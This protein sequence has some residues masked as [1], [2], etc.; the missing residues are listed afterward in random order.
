MLLIICC[1][2][3]CTVECVEL[4]LVKNLSEYLR[5]LFSHDTFLYFCKDLYFV[6]YF[7]IN[8]SAAAVQFINRVQ[9]SCKLKIALVSQT[10]LQLHWVTMYSLQLRR[11]HPLQLFRCS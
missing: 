1:L 7:P 3:N 4:L 9:P 11:N 5:L 10:N 6:N 8:I 2:K